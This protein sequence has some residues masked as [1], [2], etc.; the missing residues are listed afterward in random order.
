MTCPECGSDELIKF[1]KRFAFRNGERVRVQQ[2]QCKRCGRI[3]VKPGKV[4]VGVGVNL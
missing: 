1:G 3:T 4:V 2:Y